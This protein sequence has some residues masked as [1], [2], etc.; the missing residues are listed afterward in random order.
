MALTEQEIDR[1]KELAELETRRY[2]DDY[3]QNV[4]PEQMKALRAHTYT[5][6]EKHNMNPDAHGGVE[7][8]VNRTLWIIAG[9]AGVGG[10]GTILGIKGILALIAG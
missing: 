9:A 1:I 3:L 4:F 7:K 5:Q 2:F 8:K 6:I 10:A